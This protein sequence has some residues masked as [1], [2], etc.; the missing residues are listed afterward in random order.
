MKDMALMVVQLFEEIY[1]KYI[2]D[3]EVV[4]LLYISF[5][6]NISIVNVVII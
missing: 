1:N 2:C 5:K 6:L 4:I 3:C